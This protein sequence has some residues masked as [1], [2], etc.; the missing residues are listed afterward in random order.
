MTVS[1]VTCW[2]AYVVSAAAA[3]LAAAPLEELLPGDKYLVKGA[4]L[5]T[6][7]TAVIYVFSLANGNTSIY[8]PYW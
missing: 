1:A 2:A 3:L 6:L 8:D 7:S 4:I 5:T